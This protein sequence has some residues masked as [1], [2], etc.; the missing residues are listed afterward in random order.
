MAQP[1]LNRKDYFLVVIISLIKL[2]MKNIIDFY[3]GFEGEPELIISTKK[4][5]NSADIIIKLWIGFFDSILEKIPPNE[6]G[7]W[8]GV[9][10][11]YHLCTG[12]YDVEIWEC[13]E[14]ELFLGQLEKL[15]LS[16]FKVDIANITKTIKKVLEYGIQRKQKIFFEY[17]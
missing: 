15:D 8:Q 13:Y 14:P 1:Q 5:E 6:Q 3:T 9:P 7:E 2:T 11:H 10:L 4:D 12:W 17:T 16:E